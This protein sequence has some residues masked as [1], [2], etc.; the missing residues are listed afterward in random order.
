[1]YDSLICC[2][3]YINEEGQAQKQRALLYGSNSHRR[4]DT[5]LSARL[6]L[7]VDVQTC[8]LQPS[9]HTTQHW[10]ALIRSKSF[11]T[12]L[13]EPDRLNYAN[14]YCPSSPGI[15]QWLLADSMTFLFFK[16]QVVVPHESNYSNIHDSAHENWPV[17]QIQTL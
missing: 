4:A 14:C 10:C 11:Y 12:V 16:V 13:T 7:S 1:M 6:C 17:C 8:W 9:K 3:W 5:L 15:K 2:L